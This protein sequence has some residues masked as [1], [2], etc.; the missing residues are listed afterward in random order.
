MDCVRTLLEPW[1]APAA[2][3]V[4]IL[5]SD[6]E[7]VEGAGMLGS[8]SAA[9]YVQMAIKVKDLQFSPAPNSLAPF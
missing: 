3:E 6:G 7:D 2:S 4:G 9:A 5:C 1:K 8:Y